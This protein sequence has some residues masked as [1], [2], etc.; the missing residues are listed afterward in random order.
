M[1]TSLHLAGRGPRIELPSRKRERQ[2][3]GAATDVL[4][5]QRNRR[6]VAQA[7][8]RVLPGTHR[9]ATGNPLA[10]RCLGHHEVE[11]L[12]HRAGCRRGQLQQRL[13]RVRLCGLAAQA[14][15]RLREGR[16]IAERDAVRQRVA[17][18][19][20]GDRSAAADAEI[21]CSRLADRQLA[22]D[23]AAWRW[24]ARRPDEITESPGIEA[25]L[26]KKP[27]CERT[28]EIL[29]PSLDAAIAGP[30]PCSPTGTQRKETQQPPYRRS[31]D[32]NKFMQT[33]GPACD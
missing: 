15:G 11:T 12:R 3:G 1:S 24:P 22:R 27:S 26:T 2:L 18:V 19:R 16:A 8:H 21:A 6:H 32:K 25:V 28:L 33:A 20:N 9:I 14:D 30:P 5:T 4:R 13:V 10:G 29:A 23:S 7:F 31:G 17:F